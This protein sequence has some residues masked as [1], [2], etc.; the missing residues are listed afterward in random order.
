MTASS[1]ELRGVE[2]KEILALAGSLSAKIAGMLTRQVHAQDPKPNE[3][4]AI[5]KDEPSLISLGPGG[6]MM[7]TDKNKA[8]FVHVFVQPMKKICDECKGEGRIEVTLVGSDSGDKL[9]AEA[10]CPECNGTGYVNQEKD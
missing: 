1:L 2:G 9:P 8:K 10:V 7:P 5:V 4:R 6:S 3:A